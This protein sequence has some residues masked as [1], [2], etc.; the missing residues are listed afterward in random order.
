[1]LVAQRLRQ[2]R[3]AR[4]MSLD[5]LEAAIGGVVTKQA[6]SKYERGVMRPS[7]MVLNQ[8]A[9]V[10]GV[11]SASLW[12]DPSCEIEFVAYR[13]GS[14]LRKREQEQVQ[15]IVTE[16]LEERVRFQRNIPPENGPRL[17]V[18][19]FEIRTL[20]DTEHFAGALREQWSLGMDPIANLVNVLEDRLVHVLE[21]GASGTFDGISAVARDDD[22][23]VLAAAVVSR[24]G[25]PG[26]RQRLNLA[27]EL[28]HL[29]LKVPEG[30]D[31]EKVAF[32]FGAAFLAPSFQ[33]F[34][35]VGRKRHLVR[36]EELLFLK[37]RYGMSLQAILYRL[38]DLEIITE[39]HYKQWCMD[40]SRLGW[41]RQEPLEMPPERPEHFH[42]AVLRALSENVIGEE[43]AARL[44]GE[45]VESAPVRALIER[46]AFLKLP[47]E[48]R[49]R[50]L[51]E[52]AEQMVAYYEQDA[53]RREWE[54]GDIVEY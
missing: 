32:R 34:R 13:K 45:P 42:Q 52:Q 54:G 12:S 49:R 47:L 11:K 20:E 22:G 33:L 31:E 21:I 4:G 3:L 46:R 15:S 41:R 44:L 29:V 16:T 23:T 18:R 9:A 17:P 36:V 40:V 5:D 28:G 27:H 19:S 38:R 14:G 26:E 1:M 50:I 37:R 53:E 51:A 2:F 10:L 43:E 30:L 24:R 48:E 8:I 7:P 6:L 39:S 25:V 35:E